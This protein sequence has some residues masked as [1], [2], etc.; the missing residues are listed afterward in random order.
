MANNIERFF[1]S[2]HYS[3]VVI[4][5]PKISLKLSNNQLKHKWTQN[6]KNGHKRNKHD[7]YII[8]QALNSTLDMYHK[9]TVPIAVLPIITYPM[10]P[11]PGNLADWQCNTIR[12]Y[13][14]FTV[15]KVYN[16][17]IF[18][19]MKKFWFLTGLP[20]L[21]YFKS[22]YLKKRN[23]NIALFL[24]RTSTCFPI[25]ADCRIFDIYAKIIEGLRIMLWIF[26]NPR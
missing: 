19:N 20:I 16:S 24:F 21:Q 23:C 15:E 26:W 22:C 2:E 11:Q 14:M 10:V 18:Y 6:N 8:L 7:Q 13:R 1:N 12:H 5:T 9:S 25:I 3:S 17:I 4:D